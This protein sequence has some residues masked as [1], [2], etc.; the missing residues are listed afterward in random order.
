LAAS[1]QGSGQPATDVTEDPEL[2]E[3]A[4][5]VREAGK[6]P[7]PTV[8]ATILRLCRDRFLRLRELAALLGRSPEALRD[9]YITGLVDEDLLELRYADNRSHPDQA[10]RTRNDST[11]GAE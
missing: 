6:A 11:R 2:R 8:R 10:Y 1:P 9:S 3:I 7:R 4:A 5:P